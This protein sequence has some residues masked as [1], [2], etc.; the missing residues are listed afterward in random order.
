MKKVMTFNLCCSDASVDCRSCK[1]SLHFFVL[2]KDCGVC[3]YVIRKKTLFLEFRKLRNWR[4]WMV[5]AGQVVAGGQMVAG[6]RVVAG[7]HSE[8]IQNFIKKRHWTTIFCLYVG[9]RLQNYTVSMIQS[10]HFTISLPF[11]VFLENHNVIFT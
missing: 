4:R 7:G 2:K 8:K 10:A 5:A 1:S 11:N 9:T 6:G 3:S